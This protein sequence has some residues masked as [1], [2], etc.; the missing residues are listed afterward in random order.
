MKNIRNGFGIEVNYTG[1]EPPSGILYWDRELAMIKTI[2]GTEVTTSYLDTTI[3][4]NSEV[5]DIIKWAKDMMDRERK[6]DEL[7]E[8]HPGLKECRN[9]FD[10]MRRLCEE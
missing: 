4:F 1:M 6:L 7:C 8:K 5:T 10:V 9:T 2:S 3:S